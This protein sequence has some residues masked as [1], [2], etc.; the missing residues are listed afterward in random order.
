MIDALHAPLRL[1]AIDRS[2][3]K[4]EDIVLYL[5]Q[6][7]GAL[8]EDF[9]RQVTQIINIQLSLMNVGTYYFDLPDEDGVYADDSWRLIKVDDGISLEKKISGTWTRTSRWEY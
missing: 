6:L 1:P 4:P 3:R 5:T 7:V 8:Q 2:I 9:I